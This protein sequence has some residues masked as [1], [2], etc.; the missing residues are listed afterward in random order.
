MIE[1]ERAGL[2]FAAEGEG[3]HTTVIV[4]DLQIGLIPRVV[5]VGRHREPIGETPADGGGD[6]H[7]TVASRRRAGGGE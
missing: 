5:V 4:E 2:E 6:K 3:K 1:E 7:D